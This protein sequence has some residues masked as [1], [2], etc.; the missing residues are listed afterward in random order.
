MGAELN[1][2]RPGRKK[3]ASTEIEIIQENQED[4]LTHN[5]INIKLCVYIYI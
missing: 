3:K 4:H 5:N 2:W 1:G